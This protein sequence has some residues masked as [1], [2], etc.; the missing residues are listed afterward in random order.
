M[1]KV[2][3]ISQTEINW[4]EY[5][6]T[7]NDALNRSPTATIDSQS[8]E[9]NF[10]LSNYLSTLKEIMKPGSD[11]FR[12]ASSLLD[13]VHVSFIVIT[14][15]ET[16]LQLITE[17]RL[18][19]TTTETKHNDYYLAVVSGTLSQ[20]RTAVLNCCAEFVNTDIRQFGTMVL[21]VFEQTKIRQF[22]DGLTRVPMAD[23]TVRLLK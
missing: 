2:I 6:G 17:T 4:A 21:N 10:S 1:I 12:D 14:T 9:M 20:W 16:M 22:L 11:P 5:L 19:F 13:H 3:P 15:K 23:G 7:L 8:L 18:N